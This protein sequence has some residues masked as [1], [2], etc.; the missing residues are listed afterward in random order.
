MGGT[1]EYYAEWYQKN[2][3]WYLSKMRGQVHAK[4]IRM[5]ELKESLPCTDCG[6]YYPYFMTDWDHIGTDK[7]KPVSRLRSCSW[8]TVMAEVAKCELVCANCH[9]MRT[10]ERNIGA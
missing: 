2:K 4:A 10:H 5:K 7:R 3:S 6:G 9:R 8:E 1:K